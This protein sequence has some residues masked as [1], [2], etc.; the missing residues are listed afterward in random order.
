MKEP[1]TKQRLESIERFLFGTVKHELLFHRWLLAL[2]LTG[3]I[4]ILVAL[5]MRVL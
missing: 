5:L 3:G 4:A 2:I 1:T